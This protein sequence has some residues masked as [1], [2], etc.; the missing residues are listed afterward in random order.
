MADA[1]RAELRCP[2][3][4]RRL[5]PSHAAS[6]RRRAT[7]ARQPANV[8]PQCGFGNRENPEITPVGKLIKPPT[9]AA[10]SAPSRAFFVADLNARGELAGEAQEYAY[11]QLQTLPGAADLIA[12][13]STCIWREPE[14]LETQ[15]SSANNLKLR[16]LAAAPTAG[17]ATV[18]WSD[19]LASLSLLCTGINPQ[20]DQITLAAFQAKLLRELH[21][22]G[23][24][25]AFDLMS[26]DRRPLVA[27]INFRSPPDPHEQLVVA[28]ADRCFAAS[29][30]RYHGLA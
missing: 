6:A 24:E 11:D 19:Q 7:S 12:Q 30:F 25:P 16:W 4:A 2:T 27:T 20:A 21:D 3:T 15:I 23:T 14:E 10:V 17:I 29:Y 9:T 1:P 22:T 5:R 8:A 13:F 28:L 26:I 18:R